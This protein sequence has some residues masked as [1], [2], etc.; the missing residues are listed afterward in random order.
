M[1]RVNAGQEYE[2]LT[3]CRY[4]HPTEVLADVRSVTAAYKDLHLFVDFYCYSNGDKKK[5]INLSGTIPIV[6][7]G[8]VYNIPVCIWLHDTHPQSPPKCFIR[9]SGNM[10]INPKCSCV[11][12]KGLVLLQ[13][14]GN[15]QHGWSNLLIVMEEMRAAFQQ[16]TPVFA[17]YPHPAQ[18][19]PLAQHPQSPLLPGKHMPV[20]IPEP[21]R[22][23]FPSASLPYP[24]SPSAQRMAALSSRTSPVTLLQAARDYTHPTGTKHSYSDPGAEQGVKKSYTE[25]LL[26]LGITFGAPI[27][28]S[29]SPSPSNPF[30]QTSAA[31]VP[32]ATPS[33]LLDIDDL[34]KSL[35]LEKVAKVYQLTPDNKGVP[36]SPVRDSGDGGEPHSGSQDLADDSH[37]I[38]VTQLPQGVPPGK[39]RNKLTIYFQRRHNGGGEV[40]DVQYPAAQPDQARVTFRDH[41]DAE[42]ILSQ[43]EHVITV[44]EK[45][46]PVQVKRV[47]HS[48]VP[49]PDGVPQDKVNMF[50]SLLSLD[51]RSF[52]PE[53]VLEAVQSC[54]DLPS[55]LRY[56]SH[57]CPICQEQVSF[58]KIITMTHCSCAFCESCFKAYFSSVIKEKSIVS[59]VCPLCT[60]PD[61]RLPGR[62][63]EAMDYFSLLDTQIRHYLDPQTH[64][65]FQRKLRD[66]ALLEMANFR[67]CAHCSFGLLHEADRLRMDC[68][69]CKKSTCSNCRSP[70]VPQ[71][72]GLSCEKF[73]KWQAQNNPEYQTTRLENLL[74]SNK[75]DCPK[76]KFRF[77]LSKGGCLHFKCT[78]CQYEFCGGCK[79]SFRLGSACDFSAECGAKGLHAHHPRDCLYHLRDWSVPRLLQLLQHHKV[80][81]S[82]QPKG[83]GGGRGGLWQRGLCS[84]LEQREIGAQRE[85][86]CGEPAPTGYSGYCERH[87]KECLVEL[88]NQN[89]LDPAVLFDR[90]EMGA[91]LQRWNVPVP[92]TNPQEPEAEYLQR[93]RWAVKQI[94]LVAERPLMEKAGIAASASCPTLGIPW[95]AATNNPA[96]GHPPDSQLLLL[97]N[98]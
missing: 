43:A 24:Q 86:P 60:E 73:R 84:V 66:H 14:L 26:D 16:E 63:E 28:H 27:G 22:Q 38:E 32:H 25:E 4:C 1:S 5:L 53:E 34:F 88:I 62:M 20:K 13:C 69:S 2:A 61:V 37:T 45:H 30:S 10:V 51:G 39:M 57:E 97:L 3:E 33:N 76:C 47:D 42:R 64:E 89:H 36:S 6:Y 41:R 68:P 21:Y 87:Y 23:S 83:K 11:D 48:Q 95:S 78:Q 50:Q 40:L 91:E 7:E 44:N 96:R 75:I 74:S 35:Q 93:L 29:Y 17:T 46:F 79:R 59:V 98:D 77:Y 71:H 8:N 19:P 65:L 56:L 18:I 90:A 58:S 82:L 12:S 85:E 80:T 52:T 9:P 31:A 67:W 70:W 81:V 49:V 72:E 94:S 15:W 55:A 54:W 92:Q